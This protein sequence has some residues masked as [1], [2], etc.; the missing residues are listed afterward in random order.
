[1]ELFLLYPFRWSRIFPFSFGFEHLDDES[2]YQSGADKDDQVGSE[3]GHDEPERIVEPVG[4][5]EKL[6]PKDKEEAAHCDEKD[7]S[8][9][10]E[11][12]HHADGAPFT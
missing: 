9:L 1:M 4:G 7:L 8:C 11:N 6:N 12:T 2:D 5:D 3:E 10:A